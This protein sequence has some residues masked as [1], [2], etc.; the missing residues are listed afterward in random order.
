MGTPQTARQLYDARQ[1]AIE[2]ARLAKRA[3]QVQ[4]HQK[5]AALAN[6][7]SAALDAKYQTARVAADKKAQAQFRIDAKARAA[8]QAEYRR[9]HPSL[10]VLLGRMIASNEAAGQA[11]GKA[12][13]DAG[14]LAKL[15]NP[16]KE[17]GVFSEAADVIA[18]WG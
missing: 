10:S 12:A 15:Q 5:Q 1:D 14:N 8:K 4:E 9:K 13:A 11:L 2:K 7:A 6:A 3:G 17:T 16:R 18:L